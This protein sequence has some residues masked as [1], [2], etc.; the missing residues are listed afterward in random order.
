MNLS[1]TKNDEY[2]YKSVKWLEIV[3]CA[4]TTFTWRCVSA[5]GPE[6]DTKVSH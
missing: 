3:Y 1:L 6:N 5:S 4:C 2:V